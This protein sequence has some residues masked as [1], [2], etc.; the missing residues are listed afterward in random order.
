MNNTG[1]Q[2]RFKEAFSVEAVSPRMISP[3]HS[4]SV[5]TAWGEGF[6][7]ITGADNTRQ[8]TRGGV[9]VRPILEVLETRNDPSDGVLGVAED[10]HGVVT[11]VELVV[12][13]R[14]TGIH[15]ALEDHDGAGIFDVEDRHA[16]DRA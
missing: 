12:Y 6:Q 14:E 15:A 7:K 16:V 8:L 2:G 3:A 4:V 11:A 5:N 9:D 1:E 13:A 10:H